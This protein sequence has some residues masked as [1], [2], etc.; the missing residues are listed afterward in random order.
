MYRSIM[1]PLDGSSF[2][3]HALPLAHSIARRTR[4]TVQ[5]A[6][7][8]VPLQSLIV[9]AIPPYDKQ[10]ESQDRARERAYLDQ[11]AQRLSA[12]EAIGI[13]VSMLEGAV[14][15]ALLAHAMATKVD[16]FVMATHGRGALSRFWLGSV[17]DRLVRY[18]TAPVLLVRPQEGQPDLAQQPVIRHVLVPLDGSA[19]AEQAL[20]HAVALG[21]SMDAAYTLVQ[22][23]EPLA[24][25][26]GVELDAAETGEPAFAQL[27]ARAQTYLERVAARLRAEML[28][29]QTAVVFGPAA[30]AIL[31]Y[32]RGQ[33]VDLIAMATHGHNR[34]ANVLM[35]GV[36]DKVLR[37]AS[38]PV[39]MYRPDGGVALR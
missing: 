25:D 6:H 23:I 9:D 18:A 39:L 34:I 2:G 29:V 15:D 24:G 17:T 16:L 3:E 33:P 32:A 1:V 5:L 20:A 36:A 30:R 22:A 21:R 28:Q 37:G 14:A 4:A 13:T 11:L 19:P 27:R 12:D 8:Y 7:V 10:A 31:E 35:G 26:Y 38:V